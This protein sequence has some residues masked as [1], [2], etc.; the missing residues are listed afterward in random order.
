[1]YKL[2]IQQKKYEYPEKTT[3]LEIAKQFQQQYKDDIVLVLFNNRL[4]ELSKE[5]TADG[6]LDFVTTMDKDGKKAYRRSVTLLMQRAVYDLAKKS[7]KT[8]GVKVLH[9][10]GQAYYCE[11]EGNQAATEEY[12][13]EL[14]AEMLRIVEEKRPINKQSIHTEDAVKLFAQ[15]G[16]N[17][18]EKLFRYRRS[19]Q[20]NI[21]SIGNYTDYFYGY[22]VPDT[23]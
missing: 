22:M 5:V 1:M 23:G 18:K 17:D 21:Y 14:K 20:M 16:M 4:R 7:G 6:T 19:S 2:T 8:T 13:T 15:L 3:F 9:S 11:L 12:L 10:I